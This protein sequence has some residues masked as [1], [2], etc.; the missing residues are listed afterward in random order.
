MNLRLRGGRPGRHVVAAGGVV[1]A[2]LDSLVGFRRRLEVEVVGVVVQR[3]VVRSFGSGSGGAPSRS[4][5]GAPCVDAGLRSARAGAERVVERVVAGD[6]LARVVPLDEQG[7]SER[8]NCWAVTTP[9]APGIGSLSGAVVGVDEVRL[10]F[11]VAPLPGLVP[12]VSS[13]TATT[14]C[15]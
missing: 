12:G 7:V 3:R 6:F 5:S 15:L 8:K 14:I 1:A 9:F 13:F 10:D 4:A 11:D 2:E